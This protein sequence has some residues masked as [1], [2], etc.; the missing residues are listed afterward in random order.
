MLLLNAAVRRIRVSVR[1][2]R[3]LDSDI[4]SDRGHNDCSYFAVLRSRSKRVIAI[5]KLWSF[6]T[7]NIFTIFSIRMSNVKRAAKL[8]E[9]FD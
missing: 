2:S 4:C 1:Q 6:R 9:T 7:E 5:F 3:L 8:S